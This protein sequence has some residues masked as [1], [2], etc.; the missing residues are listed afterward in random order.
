[1]LC[2]RQLAGV[3]QRR[4]RGAGSRPCKLP[5]L[6]IDSRSMR[7]ARRNLSRTTPVPPQTSASF[8]LS[9]SAGISQSMRLTRSR[10]QSG[11][12]SLAPQRQ[13]ASALRSSSSA[14][15]N[16]LV[17]AKLDL[18]SERVE[19]ESDTQPI[20][21]AFYMPS[22]GRYCRQT[23]RKGSQFCENHGGVPDSVGRRRV[24]C[25]YDAKQCVCS[26]ALIS[27]HASRMMR[28]LASNLHADTTIERWQLACSTDWAACEPMDAANK[29]RHAC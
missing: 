3:A 15:S 17:R 24:P 26:S 5:Q 13:R 22:K 19:A 1:M 28:A 23:A 8:C 9:G 10:P 4:V 7:L 6:E 18:Q 2:L 29:S 12:A 11:L 21:C 14:S 25:P 16:M 20:S 27:M